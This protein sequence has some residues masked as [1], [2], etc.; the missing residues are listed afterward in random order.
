M[1]LRYAPDKLAL[2]LS[3]VPYLVDA[4]EVSISEA[5]KHFAV[6]E[7]DIRDA[8]LLIAVSG[9]PSID[10]VV[11]HGDMFDI[12]WDAFE[13]DNVISLTNTVAIDDTP[14]FSRAEVS[15]LIAGLQYLAGMPDNADNVALHTV[16]RK[17]AAASDGTESTLAVAG[18][19]F[20]HEV[21]V[22]RSA[23]TAG[24]SVQFRYASP[25]G[26]NELR[27]IDP[28]QL[29]S[30]NGLWYLRGWCSDRDALR[31]FRLDRMSELAQTEQ[32]AR[33]APHSVEVP[34][35]LFDESSS[36]FDVVLELERSALN[37]LG[38]YLRSAQL[39]TT[40]SPLR[41]TVRVAHLHGLKRIVAAHPDLMRVVEPAAAVRVVHDWVT[42]AAAAYPVD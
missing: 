27:T 30:E 23:V 42:A 20:D 35:T 3:L 38:D 12:D 14:R 21:H 2:L 41:V 31:V 9:V 37:L 10:N 11:L 8:V 26:R 6:T 1:T 34:D 22:I 4:G 5:A 24:R 28:L 15:A 19:R 13:D 29:E 18:G 32:P 7:K 36:D 33:F 16:Q 39:P 17:L 40:G 25:D